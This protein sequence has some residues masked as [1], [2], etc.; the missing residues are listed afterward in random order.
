M[1]RASVGHK[2][3][4]SDTVRLTARYKNRERWL[5]A[6][7]DRVVSESHSRH[8]DHSVIDYRLRKGSGFPRQPR[9]SSE[10]TVFTQVVVDTSREELRRGYNPKRH[11]SGVSKIEEP[12]FS[13]HVARFSHL[14]LE[15]SAC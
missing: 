15:V 5:R 4:L 8:S 7:G 14:L 11:Y 2:S 1:R 9:N 10:N 6:D 13:V 12:R 3:C